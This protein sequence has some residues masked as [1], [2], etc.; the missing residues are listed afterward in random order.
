MTNVSH[1]LIRYCSPQVCEQ[2]PEVKCVQVPRQ[3]CSPVCK[4]T[5]YCEVCQPSDEVDGYGAPQVSVKHIK[6]FL[7]KIVT[8]FQAPVVDS[9]G[10]PQAAPVNTYGAPAAPPQRNYG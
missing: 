8:S 1:I 2:V 9:Y 10:S 5:Y 4:P 6:T 3:Q 7:H